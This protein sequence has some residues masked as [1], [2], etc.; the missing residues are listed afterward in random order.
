MIFPKNGRLVFRPSH[1]VEV[2]SPPCSSHRLGPADRKGNL[3]LG[4][5][6]G[7]LPALELPPDSDNDRRGFLKKAGFVGVAAAAATMTPALLET[8]NILA[9]ASEWEPPSPQAAGLLPTIGQTV[10]C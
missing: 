10:N 4:P 8:Q 1:S 3:M 2:Y 6:E 5:T 9:N 7:F